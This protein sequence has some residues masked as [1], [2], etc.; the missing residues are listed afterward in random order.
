MPIAQ[1]TLKI[2]KYKS[3]FRP[4]EIGKEEK[5]RLTINSNGYVWFTAYGI[6]KGDVWKYTAL[7]KVRLKLDSKQANAIMEKAVMTIL[8]DPCVQD[9]VFVIDADVEPDEIQ[10]ID[11]S[12]V[13]MKKRVLE[14][15]VPAVDELYDTIRK[16][17]NI[18]CLLEFDYDFKTE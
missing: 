16:A 13:F 7:R 2:E 12:G 6:A 1:R 10:M 11:I 5:Q 4:L 8:Q 9:E 15:I 18:E 14:Q 3:G 17:I